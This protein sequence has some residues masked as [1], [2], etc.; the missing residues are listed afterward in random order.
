M[1]THRDEI[2]RRHPFFERMSL[3]RSVL[4]TFEQVEDRRRGEVQ[5]AE[6]E[7]RLRSTKGEVG[8]DEPESLIEYEIDTYMITSMHRLCQ[9]I[10]LYSTFESLCNSTLATEGSRSIDKSLIQSART[11]ASAGRRNFVLTILDEA[12]RRGMESPV[13]RTCKPSIR[14]FVTLR[15]HLVHSG[16]DVTDKLKS[17]L[18]TILPKI[19]EFPG[20]TPGDKLERL[21]HVG[22]FVQ[23][24][25]S[26]VARM[27]DLLEKLATDL[28]VPVDSE[29]PDINESLQNL[30]NRARKGRRNDS[31]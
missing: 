17:R 23:I 27:F 14:A 11:R 15:N 29:A 18:R 12:E 19:D 1:P 6:I 31:Y 24:P 4:E 8:E 21:G 16:L 9:I 22:C 26:F 5:D 2:R 25:S 13:W 30:M 28:I 10:P 3:L 20:S 7:M